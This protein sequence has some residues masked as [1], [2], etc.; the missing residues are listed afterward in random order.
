MRNWYYKSL[1]GISLPEYDI[2]LIAQSGRCSIC[3]EA[4]AED[5]Y[6][7]VDHDH[8]TGEVRGLLCSPCNRG[9]GFFRDDPERLAEASA[10]VRR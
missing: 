3:K 8:E 2:L 7:N 4:V 5:D 6:L 10:Y 1:Y 9:L